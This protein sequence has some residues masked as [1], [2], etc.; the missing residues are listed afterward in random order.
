VLW[1]ALIENYEVSKCG[2][3]SASQGQWARV[4]YVCNRAEL[5]TSI[6]KNSRFWNIG[7]DEDDR[8]VYTR[9]H[10]ALLTML[11]YRAVD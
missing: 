3:S 8:T 6:R 5:L 9:N 4:R 11:L 10:D 1:K 7:F 2:A